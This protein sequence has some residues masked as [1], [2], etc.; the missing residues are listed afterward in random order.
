MR[1][2]ETVAGE[3]V[4]ARC[5]AWSEG[6]CAPRDLGAPGVLRRRESDG[7]PGRA[8]ARHD[9]GQGYSRLRRSLAE[10]E[11]IGGCRS[12]AAP[13]G[14]DSDHLK[15][16]AAAAVHFEAAGQSRCPVRPC[17]WLVLDS[18]PPR[19]C[20]VATT[21][22]HGVGACRQGGRWGEDRR[23]SCAT[24]HAQRHFDRLCGALSPHKSNVA[25]GRGARIKGES[26][27]VCCSVCLTRAQP[28]GSR[29]Q[30]CMGSAGRQRAS[31][32]KGASRLAL[33]CA[34]CSLHS[35]AHR[36]RCSSPATTTCDTVD[37][38]LS[39]EPA[40]ASTANAR[41]AAGATGTLA[42]KL[43]PSKV[44][45]TCTSPP[46]SVVRSAS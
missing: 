11:W 30:A 41:W 19:L 5:M 33:C 21:C 1:R 18:A 44:A 17:S 42:A 24:S 37:S 4:Q 35:N 13:V 40:A 3:G 14:I 46:T 16:C 28:G 9:Q 10:H 12:S 15:Q 23:Q 20:P 43:A 26:D 45:V 38:L 22:L 6:L 25:C 7:Q 36:A 2:G 29:R 34:A 32:V 39:R 8:R 31:A 27:G